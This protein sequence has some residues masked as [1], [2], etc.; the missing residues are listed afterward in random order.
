M[1]A[2]ICKCICV[3]VLLWFN[4]LGLLHPALSEALGVAHRTAK[5][6]QREA[7]FPEGERDSEMEAM[8]V[9]RICSLQYKGK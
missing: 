2:Y 8:L 6:F 9:V 4:L 3:R 1:C 7:P 5:Q